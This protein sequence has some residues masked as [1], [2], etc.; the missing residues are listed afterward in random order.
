M[1]RRAL[2]TIFFC[3]FAVAFCLPLSAHAMQPVAIKTIFIDGVTVH[4]ADEALEQA[5]R[6][7]L[8]S[9]ERSLCGI[10]KASGL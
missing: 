1:R 3:L 8:E 5:R 4:N 6:A 2:K 9:A 7:A 10:A